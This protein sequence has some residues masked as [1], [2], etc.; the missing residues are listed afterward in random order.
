MKRLAYGLPMSLFISL[1][2]V[3]VAS[4]LALPALAQDATPEATVAD[5]PVTPSVSTEGFPQRGR[6]DAPVHIVEY[7]AFSAANCASYYLNVFPTISPR[8]A[9]GEVLYTIAL[10]VNDGDDPFASRA[11][12]CV[13]EQGG[14]WA[15]RETLYTGRGDGGA[16]VADGGRNAVDSFTL[17][18]S[19]WDACM[20]STRPDDILAAA[21]RQ[22]ESTIIFDPDS[23]P[24]IVVNGVPTLPDADSLNAAIDQELAEANTGATAEE[25]EIPVVT[26][27]PL[28][29]E[30]IQPP[31]DITLP[32][33]WGSGYD[34]LLLT[35]ADGSL[36]S[37][38]LAVYTGPVE[39]GQGFIVLLWGFPNLVPIGTDTSGPIQDLWGDGLRLLRLAV[40]E[41]GCNIGTDLRTQYSIGGQ[42]AMGTQFSAV[43]CPELPDT[44]G[45]FAG[46]SERGINFVFFVYTD[47]IDAMTGA[48]AGLQTVLDSVQFRIP[49]AISETEATETP[50]P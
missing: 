7:C 40:I 2:V 32:D 27:E 29:G 1:L 38:P 25:T 6:L 35:D 45:W 36:R 37:V 34:A 23:L 8:I 41:Q 28:L 16:F 48:R 26:V 39:G 46:I 47:P 3:V 31:L 13:V 19:L 49:E 24:Y 11:A 43:D 5:S 21:R 42:P 9:A 33:G 17:D 4:A 30:E 12:L 22:A 14:F 15:L 20:S 50:E 10:L 18:R 44:R